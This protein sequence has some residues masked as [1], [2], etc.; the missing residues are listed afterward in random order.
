MRKEGGENDLTQYAV[1]TH[2]CRKFLATPLG[3]GDTWRVYFF[4]SIPD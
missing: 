2:P 3:A 4:T 1:T